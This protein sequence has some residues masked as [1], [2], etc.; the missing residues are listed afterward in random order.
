MTKRKDQFENK[1]K[2]FVILNINLLEKEL[3]NQSLSPLSSSNFTL[4]ILKFVAAKAAKIHNSR[5]TLGSRQD[6]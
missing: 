4:N 2:S 3:S 5:I 1:T 6:I